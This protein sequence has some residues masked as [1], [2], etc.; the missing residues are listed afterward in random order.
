MGES[1]E[2]GPVPF[3]SSPYCYIILGRGLVTLVSFRD[4]VILV[5]GLRPES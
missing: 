2:A 1:E 5:S 4:F 3:P